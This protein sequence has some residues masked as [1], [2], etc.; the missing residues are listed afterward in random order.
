MAPTCYLRFPRKAKSQGPCDYR[1]PSI[2]ALFRQG[3]ITLAQ[4]LQTDN[5]G[6]CSLGIHIN[7]EVYMSLAWPR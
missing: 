2:L 6:T 4:V 7:H 5:Q 3:N 1:G